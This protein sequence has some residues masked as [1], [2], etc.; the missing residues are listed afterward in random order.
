MPE[1]LLKDFIGK[2]CTVTLIGDKQIEFVGK[3]V[4]VEGYWLKMIEND[5][6]RVVNGAL[7]RDI[8]VNK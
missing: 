1:E 2:N 7:I 5:S 3:L 4:G 6:S 8:K